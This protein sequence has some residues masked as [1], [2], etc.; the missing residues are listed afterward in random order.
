MAIK[1]VYPKSIY[2][3]VKYMRIGKAD[4]AIRIFSEDGHKGACEVFRMNR[5]NWTF[6]GSSET[7]DHACWMIVETLRLKHPV[8]QV[9][10]LP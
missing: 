10:K 4:F 9:K 3:M 2:P 8:I 5:G 7:E 1:R 6:V